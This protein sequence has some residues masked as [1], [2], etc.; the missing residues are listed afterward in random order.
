VGA[1]TPVWSVHSPRYDFTQARRPVGGWPAL[2][3]E[4]PELGGSP[5][6][7][8]S[9][10]FKQHFTHLVGSPVARDSLSR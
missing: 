2:S 10:E 9:A 6:R 5:H 8:D 4:L 3:L 7:G 1:A